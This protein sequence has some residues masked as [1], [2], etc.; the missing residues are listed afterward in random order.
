MKL[1]ILSLTIV[2]TCAMDEPPR[3]PKPRK[4]ERCE[5]DGAVGN[6]QYNVRPDDEFIF[7]TFDGGVD[8]N[9]TTDMAMKRTVDSTG[10]VLWRFGT[11]KKLP[12]R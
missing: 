6:I 9:V 2:C 7:V 3:E 1:L 12:D 8:R 4:G 5:Y 10:A 11:K